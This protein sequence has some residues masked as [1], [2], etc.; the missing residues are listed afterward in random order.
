MQYAVPVAA[1]VHAIVGVV[2]AVPLEHYGNMS[3]ICS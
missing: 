3:L 2:V 1:A